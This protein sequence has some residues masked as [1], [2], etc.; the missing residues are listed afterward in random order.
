[1]RALYSEL[2]SGL[3]SEDSLYWEQIGED[4][5]KFYFDVTLSGSANV[6]DA[7]LK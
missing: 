1:M 5:K 6:L 4:T 3:L 2:F 7:L